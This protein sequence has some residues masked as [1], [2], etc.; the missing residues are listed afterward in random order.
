MSK[1]HRKTLMIIQKAELIVIENKLIDIQ[2]LNYFDKFRY[3]IN[4]YMLYPFRLLVNQAKHFYKLM[5]IFILLFALMSYFVVD[6]FKF[7]DLKY[8]DTTKNI[9][10]YFFIILPALIMTFLSLPSKNGLALNF[11]HLDFMSQYLEQN[12]ETTEEANIINK[13]IED[14]FLDIPLRVKLLRYFLFSVYAFLTYKYLSVLF[15]SERVIPIRD[16]A[17]TLLFFL[18]FIWVFSQ[19][20]LNGR[21][22]IYRLIK[23]SIREREYL[24]VLENHKTNELKDSP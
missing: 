22:Y 24:V 3:I 18:A 13:K 1:L 15:F 11:K 10:M 19:L 7:N 4:L 14:Y 8:D 23:E 6:I 21:D 20:Y 16:G 5:L 17:N 12:I 9:I 2:S